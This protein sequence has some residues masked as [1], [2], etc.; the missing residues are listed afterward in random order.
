MVP[1]QLHRGSVICKYTGENASDASTTVFCCYIIAMTGVPMA[2]ICQAESIPAKPDLSNISVGS[3][4]NAPLG[5]LPLP[6]N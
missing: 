3:L 2:N 4:A 6:D 5:F 1:V